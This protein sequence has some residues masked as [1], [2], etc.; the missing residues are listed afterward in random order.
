MNS[1]IAPTVDGELIIIHQQLTVI[2]CKGIPQA[3]YPMGVLRLF[4][5]HPRDIR[6]I[7][8]PLTAGRS[9]LMSPS[10]LAKLCKVLKISL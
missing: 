7:S 5:T 9:L 6:G 3:R 10:D 8:L 1:L 2:L 4:F